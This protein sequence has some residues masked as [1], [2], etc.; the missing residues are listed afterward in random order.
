MSTPT[1]AVVDIGSNSIKILVASPGSPGNPELR[2]L[3]QETLE[4]RI[5]GGLG[6]DQSKLGEAGMDAGVRAITRLFELAAPHAP[7]HRKIVATSAVRD[8]QN[9]AEF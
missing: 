9:R 7:T 4:T 1:L 6:Q 5:S 2:V 8:A 3:F